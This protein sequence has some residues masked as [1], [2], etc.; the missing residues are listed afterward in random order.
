MT[1]TLSV[2]YAKWC[3]E[4]FPIPDSIG[5][6]HHIVLIGVVSTYLRICNVIRRDC[7]VLKMLL[8]VRTHVLRFSLS[9]D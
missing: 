8:L 5:Q 1:V 2:E 3:P 9:I 7:A 6:F 4:P